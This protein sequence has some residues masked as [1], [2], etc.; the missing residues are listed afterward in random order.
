MPQTNRVVVGACPRLAGR[1]GRFLL[2]RAARRASG[3]DFRQGARHAGDRAS[4]DRGYA[5]YRPIV[6]LN[7][8]DTPERL[9]AG[10]R[11]LRRCFAAHLERVCV[12]SLSQE[13]YLKC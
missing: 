3:W 9:R 13:G 4:C 6:L 8:A 11:K 2:P 7:Q 1:W 12:M 10:E 5:R